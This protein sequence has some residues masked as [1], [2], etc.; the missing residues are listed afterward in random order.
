[1]L[2]QDF[3]GY[4]EFADKIMNTSGEE[5]L[6]VCVERVQRWADKFMDIINPLPG[7]GDVAIVITALE[8]I[9]RTLRK[10]SME[11]NFLADMLEIKI[12]AECK[13][14]TVKDDE[15]TTEADVRAYAETL[16]KK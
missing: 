13:T 5:N 1:M 12:G 14:T 10:N 8:T 15:N 6:K 9:A 3:N 7:G 11:A 16:K 4:K 2:R